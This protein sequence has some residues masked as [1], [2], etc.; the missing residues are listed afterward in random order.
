MVD[1]SYPLAQE[2]GVAGGRAWMWLDDKAE[3]FIERCWEAE[4]L[5]TESLANYWCS[6]PTRELRIPSP[7][8]LLALQGTF[9]LI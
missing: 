1:E 2:Q 4:I 7:V 8:K 6:L 5:A 3:Q 9:K